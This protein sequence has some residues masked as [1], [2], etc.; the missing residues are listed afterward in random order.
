LGCV[1]AKKEKRSN[2]RTGERNIL[3]GVN[4]SEPCA[5][6]VVIESQKKMGEEKVLCREK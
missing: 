3:G 6:V 4:Y 1:E 5:A 2:K